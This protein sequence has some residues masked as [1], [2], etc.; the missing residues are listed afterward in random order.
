L[1]IDRSN[2]S[3]SKVVLDWYEIILTGVF[4]PWNFTIRIM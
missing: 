3:K 2:D 1:T 4:I